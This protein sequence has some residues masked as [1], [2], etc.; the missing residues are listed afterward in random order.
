M[1][2][3]DFGFVQ[4]AG[5]LE[6][7]IAMKGRLSKFCVVVVWFFFLVVEVKSWEGPVCRARSFGGGQLR[8]LQVV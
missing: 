1:F 7:G 2:H 8:K 4:L 3:G 6:L 5:L